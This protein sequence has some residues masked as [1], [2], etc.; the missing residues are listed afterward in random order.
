MGARVFVSRYKV[1][2]QLASKEPSQSAC[3]HTGNDH[4]VLVEAQWDSQQRA[5]IAH[6]TFT[7]QRWKPRVTRTD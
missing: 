5:F 3:C 1:N 7:L 2:P 4:L 6:F